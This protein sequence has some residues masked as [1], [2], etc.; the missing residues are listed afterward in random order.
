MEPLAFSHRQFAYRNAIHPTSGMTWTKISGQS[1]RHSVTFFKLTSAQFSCL[2][3]GA[4]CHGIFEDRCDGHTFSLCE[5]RHFST[6]RS[7]G[8]VYKPTIEQSKAFK[9]ITGTAL[10]AA[11][12]EYLSCCPNGDCAETST[13]KIDNESCDTT[14]QV[15]IRPLAQSRVHEKPNIHVAAL[16][17]AVH[18]SLWYICIY[19]NI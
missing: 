2:K 3:L 1:C 11:V 10:K 18:L 4:N 6:T 12:R 9:A 5:A 8:C 13:L 7:V 17:L 15:L 16:E 19:I 14:I